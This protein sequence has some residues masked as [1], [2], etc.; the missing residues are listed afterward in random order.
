M[1][2]PFCNRLQRT[3]FMSIRAMLFSYVGEGENLN[4]FARKLQTPQR[5]SLLGW[6][7]ERKKKKEAEMIDGFVNVIRCFFF[8]CLTIS[9]FSVPDSISCCCFYRRRNSDCLQFIIIEFIFISVSW[10]RCFNVMEFH[11]IRVEITF[12]ADLI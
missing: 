2:F 1:E 5:H 4:F 3:Y 11:P 7:E 9:R 6:N 8:V 10:K 12:V